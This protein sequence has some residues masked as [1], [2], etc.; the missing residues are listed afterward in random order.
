MGGATHN[1]LF[2]LLS[3]IAIFFIAFY[4][5]CMGGLVPASLVVVVGMFAIL[6]GIPY[7]GEW[8]K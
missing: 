5:G 3:G 4:S 7:K 8:K 6:E 2:F 1:R